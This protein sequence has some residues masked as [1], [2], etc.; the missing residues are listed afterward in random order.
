[1]RPR[2]SRSCQRQFWRLVRSG[3]RW[4]QAAAPVGMSLK[5]AQCWFGKSGGMPPLSLAE[6][7][8]ELSLSDRELIFERVK[9]GLSYAAIARELGRPTST[10]TR[11]LDLHRKDKRR[12]R[13]EPKGRETPRPGFKRQRLNYS[14]SVAQARADAAKTRPKISKLA[15]NPRL[16]AEVEAR[17]KLNHSPEQISARLV[18]D[19]PDDPEMRVS[20]ET[21]YRALYVQGRGR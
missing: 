16:R 14:P 4:R 7:S 13:A 18:I 5:T 20:H 11:E 9:E 1:M 12:P 8:R 6:P 3:V 17:L 2:L 10:V 21:I 15:G 19:F